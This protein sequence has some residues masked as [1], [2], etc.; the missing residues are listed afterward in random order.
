MPIVPTSEN[1]SSLIQYSNRKRGI[2]SHNT[3]FHFGVAL[4]TSA[5]P[6]NLHGL[7][8]KTH[9]LCHR[10]RPGVHS[11]PKFLKNRVRSRPHS[12]INGVIAQANGQYAGVTLIRVEQA[13]QGRTFIVEH[14]CVAEKFRRHGFARDMLKIVQDEVQQQVGG[15]KSRLRWLRGQRR[16]CGAQLAP[17]RAVRGAAPPARLLA[18]G[19]RRWRGRVW[20]VARVSLC[21]RAA[22]APSPRCG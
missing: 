14:C 5:D 16:L 3:T 17:A 13:E 22:R 18:S 1:P 7:Q 21:Q 4:S 8:A 9:G 2:Q 12:T 11:R 19:A 15:C 10:S 6:R 20:T